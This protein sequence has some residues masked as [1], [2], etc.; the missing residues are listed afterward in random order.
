[1]QSGS[2][3]PTQSTSAIGPINDVRVGPVPPTR[4]PGTGGSATPGDA[5]RPDP[6]EHDRMEVH[7][8]GVAR[9]A[10]AQFMAHPKT[11]QVSIKIIDADTQ[12]VIREI[13][14]EDVI[15]LAEELQRYWEVRNKRMDTK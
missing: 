8:D 4:M 9:R 14:S 12:Q 2:V 10:Y 11:G 7:V 1:M 13:P 15:R 6:S 5:P 3:D